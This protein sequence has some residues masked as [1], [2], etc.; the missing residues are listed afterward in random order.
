MNS[1]KFSS[2]KKRINVNAFTHRLL[3]HK[4]QPPS[5]RASVSAVVVPSACFSPE[6]LVKYG[7]GRQ[8][9]PQF[10][11]AVTL[12]LA[13]VSGGLFNRFAFKVVSCRH[14]AA[15][16][17]PVLAKDGWPLQDVGKVVTASKKQ[18]TRLESA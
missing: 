2:R 4:L 14:A 12:S 18:E 16:V 11:F 9:L 1:K 5:F 15:I 10:V 3:P 6:Q 8:T 17:S 13:Y 7:L